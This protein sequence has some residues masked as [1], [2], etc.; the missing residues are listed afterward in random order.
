VGTLLD[1]NAIYPWTPSVV[2]KLN[3]EDAVRDRLITVGVLRE[4]ANGALQASHDRVL[5]WA[6]AGEVERR[7]LEGE[8]TLEGTTELL[9]RLD[10]IVTQ[11]GEPIGR[12]FGYVLSDLFWKLARSAKPEEVGALALQAIRAGVAS[13]EHARHS[14]LQRP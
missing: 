3:I 2:A 11:R 12:R 9:N 5:N 13:R 8:L 14:L 6:V 10:K 4:D 7:F 1:G